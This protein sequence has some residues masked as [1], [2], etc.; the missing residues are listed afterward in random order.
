MSATAILMTLVL[1]LP[2]S[3]EDAVVVRTSAGDELKMTGRIVDYDDAELRIELAGGR[4]QTVPAEN[5]LR[6]ETRH[7]PRQLQANQAQAESRH[8]AALVL[9]QKALAV[10]R[11]RWVRRA[12]IREMIWCHRALGQIEQAGQLFLVLAR[13]RPGPSDFACMPLGWSAAPPSASLERAARAW[14]A[15]DDLPAAVLLGTSHLLSTTPSA[16]VRLKRLMVEAD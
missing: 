3:A 16:A 7:D 6:I 9:Y 1:S 15:R 2:A 11:R 10:E 8:D 4:Q 12:I 5:V 13:D 14:L